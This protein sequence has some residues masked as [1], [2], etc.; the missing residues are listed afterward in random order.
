V[1]LCCLRP[2]YWHARHHSVSFNLS[3][4]TELPLNTYLSLVQLLISLVG[5]FL[6]S[7]PPILFSSSGRGSSSS[8]E[9]GQHTGGTVCQT[10]ETVCQQRNAGSKQELIWNLPYTEKKQELRV[11]FFVV[12]WRTA[13]L[14]N[15]KQCSAGCVSNLNPIRE[16]CLSNACCVR[17]K[18]NNVFKTNTPF[19]PRAL[20]WGVA[21]STT[22]TCWSLL[23][24]KPGLD[25][26][27]RVKKLASKLHVYSVNYA[28]KFIHTK[29][30]LSSTVTIIKRRRLQVKR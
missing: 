1:L 4:S 25:S 13:P 5:V 27:S 11:R 24:T 28:A 15:K 10:G 22:I 14:F 30:V 6:Q 23:R 2:L 19:T 21:P 29:R 16:K 8:R 26:Q 12:G 7:Q 18:I 20:V 3:K 9:Q 17:D